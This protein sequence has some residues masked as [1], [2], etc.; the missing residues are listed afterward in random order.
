MYTLDKYIN[1]TF[2]LANS[3]I[4]K[5]EDVANQ[6]NY[7]LKT[8]YGLDTPSD[9]HQ[10]KYYL[11]IS[12]NKHITNSDIIINLIETNTNELLTKELL[13]ENPETRL[14]LLN[15]GNKYKELI[16]NYPNDISYINGCM[17]PVDIDVAIN[18]TAGT[19]LNM[20]TELIGKQELYLVNVLHDYVKNYFNRWYLKEY[21]ITDELYL[22]SVIATLYSS[23]PNV[24]MNY[25]LSK[26]YTN[27]AHM[28]HVEQYFRSNFNLWDDVSVLNDKSL[29]WL[30][31]NLEYIK[32]NIG[33]QN[34]RDIIIDKIFHSNGVGVAELMLG[35]EDTSLKT[36]PTL[37]EAVFKPTETKIVSNPL[38]K[39]YL[40]DR[41]T[42]Q[43][44]E[45]LITNQLTNTEL[46]S[47]QY[48]GDVFYIETFKNK[49]TNDNNVL[50][51]TK[52]LDINAIK[53]L[54]IAGLDLFETII[55]NWAYKAFNGFYNYI[56]YFI[57]PNTKKRY[58]LSPKVAFL[59]LIKMLYLMYDKD[60][61]PIV[62]KYYYNNV[63]LTKYDKEYLINN[64]LSKS[65]LND[66]VDKIL[67]NIPANEHMPTTV[68]YGNFIN[69]V[70][71]LFTLVGL[72]DN[73]IETLS[74]STDIKAISDRL[75]KRGVID[76]S[77]QPKPID[78]VLLDNGIVLEMNEL[79]DP[80]KT[81][82]ALLEAFTDTD[83]DI[84]KQFKEYNDSFIRLFN[85]LSS[86]TTQMTYN[87]D[88]AKSMFSKFTEIS[89]NHISKGVIDVRSAHM[90]PL[91]L[92]EANIASYGNNFEDR[93]DGFYID[94]IYGLTLSECNL[95][96][97]A[98]TFKTDRELTAV[99]TEPNIY[100]EVIDDCIPYYSPSV[101]TMAII[102]T[103]V[104][105]GN[106]LETNVVTNLTNYED[107]PVVSY[108]S[109][110]VSDITGYTTEPNIIGEIDI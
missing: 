86:Y 110:T 92:N 44:I 68:A 88:D 105:T 85:K 83:I 48:K 32:K 74:I 37:D 59:Y 78:D 49:V 34:T 7:G 13:L 98:Y 35:F 21:S 94:N 31:N 19:V 20:N 38:N 73:N 30:Y 81:V 60:S 11:N 9:K 8:L 69:K 58:T 67:E 42:I 23:L 103:D 108:S 84:Y 80:I 1:D 61:N 41:N 90:V 107:T 28:F 75:L 12:G 40:T 109:D 45:S 47:N 5:I 18:A 27:E 87:I 99:I 82:Y 72:I 25:R 57:D 77:D 71:N 76:L 3:F 2:K 63:I 15:Y 46:D 56:V 106:V 6:I 66:I 17:L 29:W 70:Y 64:L 93:L 26:V 104:A 52:T 16:S 22:P 89:V 10:W 33:K 100:I 95:S 101:D 50:E 96:M 53:L 36:S 39:S 54:D 55:D 4:I 91:E 24:I 97:L 62:D 51:D 79:Y 43:S 65:D 14:D 102:G